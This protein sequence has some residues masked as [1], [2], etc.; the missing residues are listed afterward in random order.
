MG[1]INEISY[2]KKF[3][4]QDPGLL[5]GRV[6]KLRWERYVVKWKITEQYETGK[7]GCNG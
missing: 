6:E 4:D 7:P 2:H 1:A 3:V 5:E